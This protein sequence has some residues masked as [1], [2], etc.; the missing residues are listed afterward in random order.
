[1]LRVWGLIRKNNKIVKDMI[2]EYLGNDIKEIDALHKCIEEICYE[3]DL[4]R[5]LWF[6]KNQREYEEYR[7]IVLTQDNFMEPIDFDT[8]ELEI[9]DNDD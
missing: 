5:P 2:A 4:Q 7:R 9:L 1:M 6:P 8:F 3:F